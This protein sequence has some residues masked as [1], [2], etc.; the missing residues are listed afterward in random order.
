MS[1]SGRRPSRL[2][3]LFVALITAASACAQDRVVVMSYNILRP[4]WAKPADPAWGQRVGGIVKLLGTHTPDIAGLQ[5]END[6]M[7]ADLLDRLPDYA[8]L[9]P[10]PEKGGRL[11]FRYRTWTPLAVRQENG[12]GGRVLTEAL[13]RGPGGRRLYVYNAHFSPFEEKARLEAA[14][15]LARMIA[16]RAETSVPVVVTGDLN[17]VPGSPPLRFLTQD[18]GGPRLT[19]PFAALGLP[20]PRTADAYT[21]H[22][23]GAGIRLDFVLF[24]G[25]LR[26]LGANAIEDKPDGVY[27]SDHL[28]VCA[29]FSWEPPPRQRP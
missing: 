22:R 28:P 5:E 24:A 25:A 14:A 8:Y 9:Y 6:S 23:P 16:T 12:P 20:S 26:P 17:S 18:D 27:P 1:S 10:V 7:V 3:L 2:I 15:L 11:L 13:F 29:V 21:A 4:E 19:D